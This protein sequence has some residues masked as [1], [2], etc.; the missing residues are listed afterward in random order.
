MRR[1][2]FYESFLLGLI[3]L[4]FLL[5]LRVPSV[6]AFKLSIFHFL[7]INIFWF[8]PSATVLCDSI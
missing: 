4:D 3:L 2:W 1:A 8:I 7:N 6:Q 5:H